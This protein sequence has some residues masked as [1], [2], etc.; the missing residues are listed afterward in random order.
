MIK[1]NEIP[2]KDRKK[3][4]LE[5]SRGKSILVKNIMLKNMYKGLECL[6]VSA[7]TSTSEFDCDKV[8]EFAKDKPFFAVKTAALKFKDDIDVCITNHY[9]TFNFPN[10]KNYIVL[11]RQEMPYGYKNWINKDLIDLNTFSETFANPPDIL[12]GSDVAARHSNSVVNGNRWEENSIDNNAFNRI[13]GPGIMNDMIVPILVHC[14]IKKI[15]MLGWDGAK[16]EEDGT[17]KHFYDLEP[18]YKP[19]MNYVGNKFNLNNLKSDTNECE[20]QIA[21]RGEEAVLNYLSSKNIEINVMSKHS[22]IS[23]KISRNLI[24]YGE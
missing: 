5:K 23:D 24:L 15:N 10:T 1:W 8:K 3:V 6:C 12:W 11:A 19:T 14:G 9:A 16:I 2:I 17:I 13:I 20:Q 22:L 21:K 7:G 18:E 4:Y